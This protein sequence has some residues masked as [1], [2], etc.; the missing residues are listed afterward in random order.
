[1]NWFDK[2]KSGI[3]TLVRKGIPENLWTQCDR[4]HQTIYGRQAEQNSGICPHCGNHFRISSSEYIN[5][6]VDNG[7]FE[8]I[9]SEVKSTDPLNFKDRKRYA[10]RLR[11]ARR[12]TGM[13]AAVCTGVAKIDGHR[14]GIGAHEPGFIMA[15]LASA[16]GERL[17][18]LIDRCIQDEI[19]LI[20][21]CRSGG[22]RMHE[23]ALS[24]MQMAKVNAKLSQFWDA[25]LLF[26]SVLTDPTTAGVAASYALVGDINIAEPNAL[27]GFTG[28]RI[29]G[30]SVGQEEQEALRQAQRAEQLLENGFLD[31]IVPRHQ[32]RQTFSKLL[33]MLDLKAPSAITK[34]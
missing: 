22:A 13:D 9:A 15:T 27:V 7:S 20:L 6:V 31:M 33:S 4:C 12:D 18:R 30:M 29:T 1:M 16:E 24:L 25:G 28:E 23:A 26:I 17:C 5:L 2:L 3:Q 19:P 10:D 11:D 14:V 34:L 8:E 32:M 21:I